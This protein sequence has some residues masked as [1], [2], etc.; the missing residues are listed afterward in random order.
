MIIGENTV[1]IWDVEGFSLKSL[2]QRYLNPSR[3][4][5]DPSTSLQDHIK[6]RPGAGTPKRFE[7]TIG[8][9]PQ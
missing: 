4:I 1:L 7:D 9:S 8:A 5:Q 3:F 6:N 2:V